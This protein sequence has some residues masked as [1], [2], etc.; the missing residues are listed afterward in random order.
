VTYARGNDD[1]PDLYEYRS[2]WSLKGGHVFPDN[3]SWQRGSWEGVTLA[4]PV[5]P[6]TIELEADIVELEAAQISR[7]TAQVRYYKF[8]TEVEENLHVSPARGEPL[9]AAKIFTD[10][11]TRGYVYRLI[12]NHKTEGK[13][14]L[15]WQPQVNDNYIFASIPQEL[16]DQE[17]S[18]LEAAKEAASEAVTAATGSVL[19]RFKDLIAGGSDS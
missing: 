8:G 10:R 6:R 17:P 19:D 15:D 13:L 3:P 5:V 11:G 18:V 14:A 16:L 2:Q 7:V 1:D 9:V 12:L 4:P